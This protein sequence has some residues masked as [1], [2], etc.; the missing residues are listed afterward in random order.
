M[1]KK[2][3]LKMPTAFT[4]LFAIIA[5]LVFLS[6]IPG[7][8]SKPAGILDIFWVPIK[9]F[10]SNNRTSIIIFVLVL[11]GFINIVIKTHTLDA[12]ISKLILKLKKREILLI[13]ILMVFFSLSGTTYGMAE[14]TLGFYALI[15]PIMFAA[16]FDAFTGLLIILLGAGIGVLG[17]II[18]PFLIGTAV[19]VAKSGGANSDLS[20]TTG[21]V[22]RIVIWFAMTTIAIT[23]VM[24]YARR[25]KKNPET[26]VVFAMRDAHKNIFKPSQHFY[27]TKRRIMSLIVFSL[28]FIVMTFY[29]IAW[30]KFGVN[31]FEKFGKTVND[32]AP[33]LT[34]FIP[35]FGTGGLI[36]VTTF[37]LIAAILLGLINWNS[38]SIALNDFLAGSSG[39][40]S[41]CLIITLAGGIGIIL[42]ET[43]MQKIIVE[44]IK[45]SISDLPKWSVPVILYLIFIP[46]S[47]L[48]PSTSGFATAIF[49]II[50]PA[51]GATLVSGAITSFS[52][53][54]G[55]V[56]LITPTSGVVMGALALSH[57]K[58]NDLIRGIWPL[59]IIIFVSSILMLVIGS[60][61]GQGIF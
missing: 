14:E 38:K 13:P 27:L 18:N 20:I 43:G 12:F 5:I 54:S 48:I 57:C 2:F 7:L 55:F 23:F 21:I 50:T 25:V 26:S 42:E 37:F 11:G 39:I 53:A 6:W 49:G 15:I 28:T 40:L 59:L 36:E 4:I 34:R 30:S 61:I 60:F 35:G 24:L 58:Y 46:L 29:L 16:G 19:E 44:K 51:L 33:Y 10:T 1:K 8:A 17:S 9:S 3:N 41:V 22:W 47:F 45:S 56:N 52:L 32:K 31:I